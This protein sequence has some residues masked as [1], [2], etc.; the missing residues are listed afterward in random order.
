MQHIITNCTDEFR[1][2]HKQG[3]GMALAVAKQLYFI[4][5]FHTGPLNKY[6]KLPVLMCVKQALRQ[7]VLTVFVANDQVNFLL[8]E[9]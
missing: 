1:L 5:Y 6:K 7:H 8:E 2:G 9:P 3:N 4:L